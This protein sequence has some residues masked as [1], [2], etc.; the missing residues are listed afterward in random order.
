MNSGV[1]ILGIVIC[2]LLLS[3]RSRTPRLAGIERWFRRM[4]GESVEQP[5]SNRGRID[6]EPVPGLCSRH[7]GPAEWRST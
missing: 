3:A 6:R 7:S 5:T 1:L 2:A 4:V